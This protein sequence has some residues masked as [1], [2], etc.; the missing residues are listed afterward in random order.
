MPIKDLPWTVKVF[1]CYFSKFDSYHP[2]WNEMSYFFQG[3]EGREKGRSSPRCLHIHWEECSSHPPLQRSGNEPGCH[4]PA[5]FVC[6]FI[7][8]V[9]FMPPLTFQRDHF[10][11]LLLCVHPSKIMAETD[12][13]HDGTLCQ[14]LEVCIKQVSFLIIIPSPAVD[15]L[16]YHS[17]FSLF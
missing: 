2:C 11:A 9:V 14:Q 17:F 4:F 12:P 10:F 15:N 16:L 6:I 13:R 5:L 1:A 7:W 3:E 8:L